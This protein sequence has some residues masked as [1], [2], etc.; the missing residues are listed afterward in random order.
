[1]VSIFHFDLRP[2]RCDFGSC[3]TLFLKDTDG[4]DKADAREFSSPALPGRPTPAPVIRATADNWIYGTVGYSRFNGE[5]NGERHNFYFGTFRL[6]GSET[7]PASTP[8]GPPGNEQGT[9]LAPQQQPQFLRGTE[10]V[11]DG[12]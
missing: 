2:W 3:L 8:W 12:C 9:P 6:D 4:D 7:P 5:V 10:P 11:H 1:M